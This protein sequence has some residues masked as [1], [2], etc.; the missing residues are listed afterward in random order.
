M[1]KTSTL[2]KKIGDIGPRIFYGFALLFTVVSLLLWVLIY[3]PH[4]TDI[5]IIGFSSIFSWHAHEMIYGYALAVVSGFLLVV[6]KPG[7]YYSRSSNNLFLINLG[8]WLVARFAA[9]SNENIF[10]ILLFFNIIF[11]FLL[12][13]FVTKKIFKTR[14]LYQLRALPYI[15]FLFLL[16]EICFY[17]TETGMMYLNSISLMHMAIYLLVFLIV[18][19]GGRLLPAVV[20][21]NSLHF[22]KKFKIIKWNSM[23]YKINIFLFPI[24]FILILISVDDK[25]LQAVSIII[26]VSNFVRIFNIYSP[27]IWNNFLILGLYIA[28]FY[29][30]LGVFLRGFQ[31]Y[32][33]LASSLYLHAFAYGGIGIMTATMMSRIIIGFSSGNTKNP[34]T[35][36][37]ISIGILM[38]GAF[39]RVIL[40]VLDSDSYHIYIL[41]AQVFWIISFALLSIKLIPLLLKG[42]RIKP[43]SPLKKE[44][45]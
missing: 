41:L 43:I 39:I 25:Y 16:I 45:V 20:E 29:I 44:R 34:D 28:I 31:G 10:K 3:G 17:L 35:F 37:N 5:Q 4:D 11:C 1:N 12:F 15:L 24:F 21:S 2:F 40:P 13:Y 36:I 6:E 7:E 30:L 8:S 18:M 14:K 19:I 9:F 23:L 42:R 26:L 27:I 38:V 33:E 22:N 32:F